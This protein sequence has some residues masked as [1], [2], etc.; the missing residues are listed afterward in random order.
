M[1]R[2][3]QFSGYSSSLKTEPEET[4]KP[5]YYI[6]RP[7]VGY[8]GNTMTKLKEE[9]RSGSFGG[10]INFLSLHSLCAYYTEA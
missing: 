4:L 9:T 6:L 3:C 2:E 5:V 1:R 10:E 8:I 7:E